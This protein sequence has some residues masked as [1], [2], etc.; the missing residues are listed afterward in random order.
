MPPDWQKL[1]CNLLS[2]SAPM[3]CRAAAAWF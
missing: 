1:A 3:R 2:V